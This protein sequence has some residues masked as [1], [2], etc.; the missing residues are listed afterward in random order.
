[1]SFFPIDLSHKIT[2]GGEKFK[3]VRLINQLT[4]KT[5]K[6][7]IKWEITFQDNNCATFSFEKNI[8]Q[9]KQIVFTLRFERKDEF[10]GYS[11]DKNNNVLRVILRMKYLNPVSSHSSVI[12]SIFLLDY[13]VLKGLIKQLSEKLEKKPTLIVPDNFEDYKRIIMQDVSNMIN[14]IPVD[15]Q[16]SGKYVKLY[17]LRVEIE[18]AENYQEVNDLYYKATLANEGGTKFDITKMPGT[19]FR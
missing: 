3:D 13:P 11:E 19:N 4:Q 17:R 18:R 12:K 1:M 7:E 10:R 6:D 14:K 5:I 2:S 16:S 15:T 9:N 8:T